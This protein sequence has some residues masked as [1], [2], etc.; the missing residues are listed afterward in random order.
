MLGRIPVT[1]R[2]NMSSYGIVTRKGDVPS[3]LMQDFIAVL[4]PVARRLREAAGGDHPA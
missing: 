2:R 3:Q 4:R 1:I